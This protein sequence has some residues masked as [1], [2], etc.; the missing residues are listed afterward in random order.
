MHNFRLHLILLILIFSL[1]SFQAFAMR[2]VSG[3]IININQQYKIAFT[4][5]SNPELHVGDIVEVRDRGKF[6]T[7]LK[8]S[9]VSNVISKLVMVT[10]KGL[11]Q[12]KAAFKDIKV[13]NSIKKVEH[14]EKNH[15]D[16]QKREIDKKA[17]LKADTQKL[18]E[19]YTT[20]FNNLAELTNEK[21]SLEIK[22]EALEKKIKKV[23]KSLQDIEIKKSMLEE[24]NKVLKASLKKIQNNN[25]HKQIKS[26]KQTIET[27]KKKLERMA[28]LI[29]GL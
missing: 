1:F 15:S 21:K 14:F 12:T 11:Y 29:E 2:N 17:D 22:Y 13:G 9:E 8:V 7:Y 10:Q 5:L 25:E 18:S 28:Q 27:L 4:D 23:E 24:E 26:L 20:L 19:S 16:L 3:E 6:I